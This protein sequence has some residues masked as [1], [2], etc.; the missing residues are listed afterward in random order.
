M[1]RLLITGASGYL[2]T[3]L[4]HVAARR[5][6]VTALVH[7]HALA[8]PGVEARVDLTDPEAVQSFV[9][10]RS[11]DAIIHAAAVNPGGDEAQ[12]WRVNRDGS[13]AIAQAACAVG[14]RLVHVSSDVIHSGREG[15]YADDAV[16]SPINVYGATK[17][18]GEAA[19]CTALPC[20]AIVRTSLIYGLDRIDRVTGD[21]LQ[22]FEKGEEVRLFSDSVRQ[23]VWIET[24]C[25]A[26]LRFVDNDYAGTV[27]VVGSQP[28]SREQ[29]G[30]RL[31]SFWNAPNLDR[32][33]ACRAREVAPTM[34]LDLRMTVA[35]GE[36]LLGMPFP[37]VDEVLGR[38]G[39]GGTR[40][41][42]RCP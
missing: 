14:A 28:L 31:L 2:G 37:G 16:P 30:M 10:A 40:D 3:R 26:L 6:D 24:L 8:A 41:E 39:R 17:A 13:G 1:K 4:C 21:F 18:A 15:P 35:H 34:P 11:P 9:R 5:F 42:P 7:T 12:M 38:H 23:P 36:K 20:S 33:R 19:V 32:V 25:D 22:R 29:F 27:N